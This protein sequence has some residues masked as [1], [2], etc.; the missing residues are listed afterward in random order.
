MI[1]ILLKRTFDHSFVN[2]V[3]LCV[4]DTCLSVP[5]IMHSVMPSVYDACLYVTSS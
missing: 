2:L 4:S 1:A 3:M 5:S